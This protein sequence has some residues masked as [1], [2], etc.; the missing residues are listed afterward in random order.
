MAPIPRFWSYMLTVSSLGFGLRV[1]HRIFEMCRAC[2]IQ[3]LSAKFMR[4]HN[5][6]NTVKATYDALT[7]QP[8]PEEIAIGRGKKL[9]DVRSVYYGG[10][11]Q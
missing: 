6:L 2:G 5:P 9:V 8:D 4:S 11:T 7:N 1:S 10:N 3:D